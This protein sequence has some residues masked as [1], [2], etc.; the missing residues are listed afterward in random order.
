MLLFVPVATCICQG[1]FKIHG[2][3]DPN[4]MGPR[5]L[6]IGGL[7]VYLVKDRYGGKNAVWT[8]YLPGL[9]K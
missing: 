7:T 5:I 6:Q 9:K 2:P 1:L 3:L 8:I 4:S